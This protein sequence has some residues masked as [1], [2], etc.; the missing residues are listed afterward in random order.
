[1]Y[2]KLNVNVRGFFIRIKNRFRSRS[3]TNRLAKQDPDHDGHHPLR[4]L[5]SLTPMGGREIQL[6]DR[7]FLTFPS[8]LVKKQMG[9]VFEVNTISLGSRDS[10]FSYVSEVKLMPFLPPFTKMSHDSVKFDLGFLCSLFK[11]LSS[12]AI[13]YQKISYR[14]LRVRSS[15]PRISRYDIYLNAIRGNDR[16]CY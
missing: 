8:C 6:C 15:H 14:G 2:L 16:L 10:S 12:C 9:S 4:K 5:W 7:V 1:M 13:W 11:K 3:R